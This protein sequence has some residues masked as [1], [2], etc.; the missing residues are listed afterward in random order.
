MTAEFGGTVLA[1]GVGGSTDLPVPLSYA[2]IGAAWALAVTF[3]VVAVAWRSPRFDP[4]KPGHPLPKWVSDAV[5]S[6]IIRWMAASAALLF[7]AWVLVAAIWGPQGSGNALPGVFYVL[8][9][10]GLAAVS[11]VVGPIWRAM[12]CV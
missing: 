6:P 4:D 9:W 2:L 11:V 1:H 12:R 7:T 5:D 3:A 8:L 10:V